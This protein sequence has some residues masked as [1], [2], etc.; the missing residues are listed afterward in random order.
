[1][2]R[3]NS[4]GIPRHQLKFVLSR[5]SI[6][7][8]ARRV[9]HCLLCRRVGVNEAGLC[10]LCYPLIQDPEEQRLIER[11]LSGEGP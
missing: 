10:D 1:V 11:W 5:P 6:V 3:F 7:A 2:E 9:N 8:T 4:E